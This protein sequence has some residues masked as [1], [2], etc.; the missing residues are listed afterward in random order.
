MTLISLYSF[1][2]LLRNLIYPVGFSS[3]KKKTASQKIPLLHADGAREV[4]RPPKRSLSPF[5]GPSQGS[6]RTVP[7]LP[8]RFPTQTTEAQEPSLRFHRRCTRSVPSTPNGHLPSLPSDL[9]PGRSMTRA[10]RI[11]V[12]SSANFRSSDRP[13]TRGS[14]Q[15]CALPPTAPRMAHLA[16]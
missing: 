8:L 5:F 9:S 6:R 10:R 7:S 11:Y 15:G 1:F 4:C 16:R 14:A 3:F 2:F 13:Q 12:S